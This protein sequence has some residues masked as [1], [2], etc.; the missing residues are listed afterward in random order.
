MWKKRITFL[1][2]TLLA[3][4]ILGYMLWSVKDNLTSAV[5]HI[6]YP[7]LITAIGTGVL[8]WYLRGGRYQYILK[9]LGTTC[10]LTYATATILI[11]QIVNIVVP[12]RLGDFTRIFILHKDK[13]T[14]YTKGFSSVIEERLFDLGTISLLSAMTLPFLNNLLPEWMTRLIILVLIVGLGALSALYLSKYLLSQNKILTKVL[15][16]LR[17]IRSLSLTP[18]SILLLGSLSLLIWMGETAICYL[19]ARMFQVSLSFTL[20]LF[21]VTI[22]NLSKTLPLTPGGVGVYEIIVTSV[23]SFGGIPL[24]TATL[25]AVIDHLIKNIIPILGGI[26][27]LYYFGD[28]AT[29]L[30]K[31]ISRK[32]KTAYKKEEEN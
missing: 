31:N 5:Q 20:V 32:G 3:T 12:A 1:L 4:G 25:I 10:G 11:G 9:E 14:P 21:A 17:Y 16:I 18:H 6:A 7:F 15:E 22:G 2:T 23:L 13:E 27:S 24:A 8:T 26:L 30:L 19:I 28:W 29:T